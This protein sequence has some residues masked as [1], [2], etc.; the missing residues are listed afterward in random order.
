MLKI[1]DFIV[2]KKKIDD[3]EKRSVGLVKEISKDPI[4]FFL[5]E[6]RKVLLQKEIIFIF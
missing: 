3:I 5:L 2:A 4:L 1:N 6:K